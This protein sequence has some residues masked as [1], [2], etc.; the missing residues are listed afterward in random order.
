MTMSSTPTRWAAWGVAICLLGPPLPPRLPLLTPTFSSPPP[1]LPACLQL[2]LSLT[3]LPRRERAFFGRSLPFFFRGLAEQVGDVPGTTGVG[4]YALGAAVR[5][6]WNAPASTFPQAGLLFLHRMLGW[7]HASVSPRMW[8]NVTP[9]FSP[10]LTPY[11]SP[12]P[13]LPPLQAGFPFP[14]KMLGMMYIM[15][16]DLVEQI[17]GRQ[18]KVRGG[19]QAVQGRGDRCK[20]WGGRRQ[21]SGA[22]QLKAV[23]GRDGEGADPRKA[24]QCLHGLAEDGLPSSPSGMLPSLMCNVCR[25]SWCRWCS[26]C[27]RRGSTR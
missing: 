19:G 10:T 3:Q 7:D 16:Y 21:Y 6:L 8:G 5:D 26:D 13:P 23:R 17:G 1:L 20:L 12:P 24:V 14:L 2:R 22:G 4:Q 25:L 27:E 15:S 9:Y 18:Y 11:F